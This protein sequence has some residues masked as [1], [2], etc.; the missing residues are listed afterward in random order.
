MHTTSL[1]VVALSLLAQVNALYCYP[2]K[3]DV[4]GTPLPAFCIGAHDLGTGSTQFT[5]FTSVSGWF[6]FGLGASPGDQ[7]GPADAMIAYQDP[8]SNTVK[9]S[10]FLTTGPGALTA[11]AAKPW[12]LVDL[13]TTI[14]QPAWAPLA[15]S[16]VRPNTATGGGALNVGG[17]SNF[18]FAWASAKLTIKSDGSMTMTAHGNNHTYVNATVNANSIS[19]GPGIIAL[20]SGVSRSTIALAHAALMI[21]AFVG[22]PPFAIFVAMFMREKF[23][24]SWV[25]LHMGLLIGGTGLLG[26]IGAVVMILFKPG[27]MFSSFH[28]ILGVVIIALMLIQFGL[29]AAARS[30]QDTRSI[31]SQIH[32]Y[33]GLI[34]TFIIVPIQL[35]LGFTEYNTVFGTAAPI[36]LIILPILFAVCGISTLVAGYFMFPYGEVSSGGAGYRDDE[37]GGYAPQKQARGR[38][39]VALDSPQNGSKRGGG[40]RNKDY[41][42]NGGGS[43]NGHRTG[44]SGNGRGASRNDEYDA[45]TQSGNNRGG[46]EDYN[47]SRKAPSRNGGQS[48]NG[49]YDPMAPSSPSGNSGRTRGQPSRNNDYPGQAPARGGDYPGNGASR[50][51]SRSRGGGGRSGNNRG[52]D[53]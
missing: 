10:S 13:N 4:S 50:S 23:K 32:R 40:S 46:G 35:Y 43:G 28:H 20:P 33:F 25:A 16:V 49:H 6:G 31:M 38:G 53:Y 48:A 45:Y 24:Y 5:I 37:F 44:G 8:N 42:Y 7:M 47:A 29:G 17:F 19:G 52:D 14:P 36:W 11:N 18:I 41:E 1:L 34:L 51:A 39:F 27:A 30:S 2:D 22:I 12:S 26:I 15:F 9:V 3:S 21:V